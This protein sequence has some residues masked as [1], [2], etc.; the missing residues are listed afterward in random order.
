[1][2]LDGSIIC[3]SDMRWARWVLKKTF[4]LLELKNKEKCD[5][6]VYLV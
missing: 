6:A 4:L 5:V 3:D 1:M 2:L